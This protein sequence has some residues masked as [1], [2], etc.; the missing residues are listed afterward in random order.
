MGEG[1]CGKGERRENSIDLRVKISATTLRT[2][3]FQKFSYPTGP[4]GNGN[5]NDNDNDNDGR[6]RV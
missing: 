6:H 4:R 1:R 5:D 3:N 2:K